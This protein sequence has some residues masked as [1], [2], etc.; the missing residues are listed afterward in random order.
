MTELEF[1]EQH[2]QNLKDERYIIHPMALK[3][4]KKD[5]PEIGFQMTPMID[6]VFL[7]LVFFMCA[8]TLAQADRA[9]D[10][11][12]PLSAESEMPDELMTRTV[13]SVDA[14]G[15][16]YM[17]SKS[18]SKGEFKEYLRAVLAKQPDITVQIRSD[19]ATP[20]AAIKDVLKI[21]AELGAYDIIY[22]TYQAS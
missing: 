2:S 15:Q 11:N 17:G 16:L 18:I 5:Y 1:Y 8:S 14:Q 4:R 22:S 13:V 3:Y 7:L 19:E 6:M 10:V 21:C 20:Y 12:L 9:I